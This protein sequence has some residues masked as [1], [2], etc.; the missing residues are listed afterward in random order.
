MYKNKYTNKPEE[1]HPF[2]ILVFRLPLAE[3]DNDKGSGNGT[4]ACCCAIS[5]NYSLFQLKA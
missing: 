5:T 3:Q 4:M 1:P 2:V